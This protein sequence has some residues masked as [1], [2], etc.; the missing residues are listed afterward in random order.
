MD[1]YLKR[2]TY[3]IIGACFEVHKALGRGLSEIVYKDALV[4]EFKLANIP[5]EREKKYNIIYKNICLPRHY[6]ADFVV[7]EKI[8][9]EI[10]STKELLAE[11]TNQVLNYLAI[12]KLKVG[13][14]VN[15]NAKSLVYKRLV[16]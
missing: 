7:K 2:E 3:K 5:F 4:E 13:L 11:H 12:S 14:L 16:L 10:K 6:F 9:L 8:I 15:F 1:L